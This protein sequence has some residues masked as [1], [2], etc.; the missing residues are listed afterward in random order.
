M[1]REE[2]LKKLKFLDTIGVKNEECVVVYGAALVLCGVKEHT[3]DIDITC[4]PTTILRLESM[5]YKSSPYRN[6][7]MVSVADNMDFFSGD[8]MIDPE[9]TMINGYQVQ[10]VQSVCNEKELRGRD[11]DLVDVALIREWLKTH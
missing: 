3:R 7:L 1:D 5:G 8:M 9:V 11:K 6:G 2:I 4:H 10:T